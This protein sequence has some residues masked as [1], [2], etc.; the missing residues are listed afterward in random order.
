M[1]VFLHVE[2]PCLFSFFLQIMTTDKT[3]IRSRPKKL[4]TAAL[5]LALVQQSFFLCAV[6]LRRQRAELLLKPLPL[7]CLLVVLV[8]SGKIPGYQAARHTAISLV[9]SL[10]GDVLMIPKKQGPFIL[11]SFFF[12]FGHIIFIISTYLECRRMTGNTVDKVKSK[13]GNNNYN[14]KK[15]KLLSLILMAA[16]FIHVSLFITFYQLYYHELFFY[17][18]ILSS[19]YLLILGFA[20]WRSLDMLLCFPHPLTRN[21]RKRRL[22]A[23]IGY[24]L[25]LASDACIALGR[26]VFKPRSRGNRMVTNILYFFAQM[27]ITLSGVSE[28]RM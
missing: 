26:Y 14:N 13:K 5:L 9:L 3:I 25:F 2:A 23:V 28:S 15:L 7:V 12:A 17:E 16:V 27:F 18:R 1:L 10:V 4:R 6:W 24:T 11:G 21:E 19:S 20:L 8:A 22:Y